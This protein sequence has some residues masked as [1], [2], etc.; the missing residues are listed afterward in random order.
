[1]TKFHFFTSQ[2]LGVFA[3]FFTNLAAGWTLALFVETNILVFTTRVFLCI[4]SL[5]LAISIEYYGAAD[6]K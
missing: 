5:Y 4:L 3:S 2:T 1:M 6:F